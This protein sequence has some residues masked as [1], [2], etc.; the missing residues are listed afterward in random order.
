MEKRIVFSA[1]TEPYVFAFSR[2]RKKILFSMLEYE[3]YKANLFAY[4]NKKIFT[5]QRKVILQDP[6]VFVYTGDNII[7]F[8][9]P[10]RSLNLYFIYGLLL[11]VITE[12][13]IEYMEQFRGKLELDENL[14]AKSDY[15]VIDYSKVFLSY[16]TKFNRKATKEV[17]RYMDEKIKS[18]YTKVKSVYPFK[19]HFPEFDFYFST[20]FINPKYY[21]VIYY[22][23]VDLMKYHL[24]L[25]YIRLIN[26]IDLYLSFIDT[27]ID[28]NIKKLINRFYSNLNYKDSDFLAF[29]S[30][31]IRSYIFSRNK[32]HTIIKSVIRR[33][34]K[35][36]T[37]SINATVYNDSEDYTYEDKVSYM[38]YEKNE[39]NSEIEKIK[40][41]A[42]EKIFN[43]LNRHK[44]SHTL[45]LNFIKDK[46]NEGYSIFED[47]ED[48]VKECEKVY[49]P[50]L[51]K[52]LSEVIYELKEV[53]V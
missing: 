13:E 16:S 20:F 39:V 48:L 33:L 42:V 9:G 51:S 34:K 31:S 1:Y 12:E 53:M 30:S 36:K 21:K 26:D 32:I 37:S 11:N 4:I 41:E 8:I 44:I 35:V 52:V 14:T 38:L 23:F 25:K 17:I 22:Y 5:R 24:I 43:I 46:V 2:R 6:C 19:S 7:K 15:I 49:G 50:D 10:Q 29:M 47:E 3:R 18:I 40:D 28:T 45:L 27:R